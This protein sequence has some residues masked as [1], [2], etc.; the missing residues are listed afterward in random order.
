M[1]NCGF[2][3][4]FGGL[5]KPPFFSLFSLGVAFHPPPPPELTVGP[6][7]LGSRGSGGCTELGH[8][9]DSHIHN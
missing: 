9:L 3:P 2:D 1:A 4:G 7:C 6:Y 5:P 8:G